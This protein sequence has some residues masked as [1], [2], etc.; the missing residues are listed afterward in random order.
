MNTFEKWM[1]FMRDDDPDFRVATQMEVCPTCQGTG[2]TWL[3]RPRWDA[4]SFTQ[5][6]VEQM[7]PE[8]WE[9]WVNGDYNS[10][11]PECNGQNVVM[12]L[13]RELTPPEYV[14]SWDEWEAD[15]ITDRQIRQAEMGWY[16]D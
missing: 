2:T 14:N 13:N 7:D 4:V 8:E 5:S 1:E 16:G 15:E 11:C 6:D 12:V 9:G 3:G 10:T